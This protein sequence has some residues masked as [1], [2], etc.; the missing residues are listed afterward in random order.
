MRPSKPPA[1]VGVSWRS[2]WIREN[3]PDI[4]C[5]YPR[6]SPRTGPQPRIPHF[7]PGDR[8]KVARGGLRAAEL[9]GRV[10]PAAP[11]S[12]KRGGK[13]RAGIGTTSISVL[14]RKF[15]DRAQAVVSMLSPWCCAG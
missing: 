7:E 14:W 12:T 13:L 6:L 10:V 5:Q 11:S 8:I 2:S 1:P 4:D 15:T 3:A 9:R